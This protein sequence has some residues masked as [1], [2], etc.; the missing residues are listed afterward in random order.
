MELYYIWLECV[1]GLGPLSWHAIL[2]EF[3]NPYDA[4]VN[5]KE[6][7]PQGRITKKQVRLIRENAEDALERAEQILE[8]CKKQN[9]DIL[10][11]NY[12]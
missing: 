10:N 6:L 5:R 9:I 12:S 2:E 3:A 7:I 8:N 11:L 1:K 4:Y